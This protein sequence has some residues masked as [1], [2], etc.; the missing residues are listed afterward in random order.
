MLIAINIAQEDL[1]TIRAQTGT[2]SAPMVK[3]VVEDLLERYLAADWID[4][5]LRDFAD[6][7]G[8]KPSA[9]VFLTR[10]LRSTL[11]EIGEPENATDYQK[12]RL[13]ALAEVYCELTGAVNPFGKEIEEIVGHDA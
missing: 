12:G 13:Y 5:E 10:E 4:G 1:N 2:D 3:A 6:E 11:D 8:D 7:L 9:D